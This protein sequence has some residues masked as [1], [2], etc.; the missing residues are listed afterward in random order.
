M[1]ARSRENLLFTALIIVCLA[2]AAWD[3]ARTAQPCA[4]GQSMEAC[5]MDA[6]KRAEGK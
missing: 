4:D 1:S 2:V 5:A 3:I 6:L